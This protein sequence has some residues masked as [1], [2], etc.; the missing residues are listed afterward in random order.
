MPNWT[1]LGLE[2][3]RQSTKSQIIT[4]V[5]NYLTALTKAQIIELLMDADEFTDKPQV[6]TGEHGITLRTQTVRDALGTVI[7]VER[8]DYNYYDT[9]EVDE[10][11]RV[12]KNAAGDEIDDQY[13]KHY[14]P[15]NS[16]GQPVGRYVLTVVLAPQDVS[17]ITAPMPANYWKLIDVGEHAS[18]WA[19]DAPPN[20]LL[21]LHTELWA[22]TPAGTFG[23]LGVAS[24]R[25]NTFLPA[26]VR[27]HTEMSGAE[28]LARRN[29]IA[30]YLDGLGCDTTELRAATDEQSQMVGIVHALSY[31]MAQLWR[32]M[33]R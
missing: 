7:R 29:R 5:G 6:T 2:Q 14:R 4:A 30:D 26:A 28:A 13:I 9:G 31:E 32:V 20:V 25:A 19:V 17:G 15:G 1:S 23:V 11:T 8:A 12:A 24:A 3:L 10:I 33:G 18:L 22:M 21:A 16:G 27:H